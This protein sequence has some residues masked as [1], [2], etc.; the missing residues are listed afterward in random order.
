[1]AGTRTSTVHLIGEFRRAVLATEN[2]LGEHLKEAP[3]PR[4]PNANTIQCTRCQRARDVESK[5]RSDLE[6]AL[7]TSAPNGKIDS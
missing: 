6:R 4:H 5:T 7:E 3:S 2:L 1:M